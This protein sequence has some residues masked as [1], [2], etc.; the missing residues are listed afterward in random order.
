MIPDDEGHNTQADLLSGIS[1][2][3]AV[4]HLLADL[5]D[6]LPGKVTRFRHLA[7]LCG[8]LSLGDG[9]PPG[10]RLLQP[11]RRPCRFQRL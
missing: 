9:C 1:D 10:A 6:D 2:L 4:S 11:G 3:D 7:D 8:A 5:H